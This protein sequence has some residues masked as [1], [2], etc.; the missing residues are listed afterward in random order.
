MTIARGLRAIALV[1]V[2]AWSVAGAGGCTAKVDAAGRPANTV[3]FDRD[4]GAHNPMGMPG[5]GDLAI[6]ELQGIAAS[7]LNNWHFVV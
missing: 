2:G 1:L 7:Q 5:T 3:W 6:A 4:G